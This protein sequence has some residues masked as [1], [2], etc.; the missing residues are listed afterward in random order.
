MTAAFA[1]DGWAVTDN[2]FNGPVAFKFFG[3][4]WFES[5]VNW[6]QA[7]DRCLSLGNGAS[8]AAIHSWSEQ[9]AIN[10]LADNPDQYTF[11]RRQAWI[12]ANDRNSEGNWRWV[13]GANYADEPI[14]WDNWYST[15]P[16][17]RNDKN[18]WGGGADCAVRGVSHG[19]A[20]DDFA[21]NKEYNAYL[22]QIRF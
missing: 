8:L 3:P 9:S 13:Q 22:C 11:T 14:T 1:A 4:E 20:W 5:G 18:P 6:Y 15:N 12:G 21:C 10:T 19:N 17:N 7:R 2:G 16:D